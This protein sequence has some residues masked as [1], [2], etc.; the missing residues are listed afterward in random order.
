MA[1]TSAFQAD[2]AGSIPAARSKML[3]WLRR[4]QELHPRV[5]SAVESACQHQ[6]L[7]P[8]RFK[9]II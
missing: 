5:R 3:I 1:I 4:Y 9:S 2:D 6:P 8:T 7:F